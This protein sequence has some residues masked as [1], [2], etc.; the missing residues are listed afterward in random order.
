MMLKKEARQ[1]KE[2]KQHISPRVNQPQHTLWVSRIC[3]NL[4]MQA[5]GRGFAAREGAEAWWEPPWGVALRLGYI[6]VLCQ[7]SHDGNVGSLAGDRDV[8]G[9]AGDRDV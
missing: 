8:G 9:L 3:L 4:L 6:S 1:K 7:L 2:G 5:M